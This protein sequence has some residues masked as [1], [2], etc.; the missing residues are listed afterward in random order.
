MIYSQSLQHAMQLCKA[1]AASALAAWDP[2]DRPSSSC[3]CSPASLKKE[4]S[5]DQ[6]LEEM[7]PSMARGT[8]EAG[9]GITA[10]ASA[11]AHSCEGALPKSHSTTEGRLVM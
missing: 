2:G 5:G 7:A 8:G 3:C 1:C 9:L 10:A 6:P 4:W 11:L